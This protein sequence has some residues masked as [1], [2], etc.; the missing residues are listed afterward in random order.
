MKWASLLLGSILVTML[1]LIPG[2]GAQT[3]APE[4][5]DDATQ[6]QAQ[7]QAEGQGQADSEVVCTP[8]EQLQSE[9]SPGEPEVKGQPNPETVAGHEQLAQDQGVLGTSTAVLADT[10]TNVLTA[11]GSS[12]LVA[13]GVGLLLLGSVVA[14]SAA[15]KP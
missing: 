13:V 1:F 2:A 7:A 3:V 6:A 9:P 14:V 11:T 10:D 5:C 4:P 12:P 8:E 15:T